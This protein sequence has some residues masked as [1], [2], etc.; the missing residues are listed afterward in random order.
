VWQKFEDSETK[1]P[2]WWNEATDDWF[3]ESDPGDWTRYQDP[4]NDKVYWFLSDS[5]WFWETP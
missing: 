3:L 4:E 1:E 5:R 2:W